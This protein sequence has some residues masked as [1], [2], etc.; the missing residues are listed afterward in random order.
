MKGRPVLGVISGALFGLFVALTLQQFGL[1]PLD[2]VSL[3]G[4]PVAGIVLGLIVAGWAP[5]G[6]RTDD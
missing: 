1:R 2:T 4:F 6:S 5:L 3:V